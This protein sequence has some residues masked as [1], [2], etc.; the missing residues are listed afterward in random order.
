MEIKEV[1]FIKSVVEFEKD[2]SPLSA[3]HD[4]KMIFFLWRSNVGKSSM[5]NSILGEKNLA[6][7]WD[8]P[9][10]TRLINIFEV[11]KKY[12]CLDF[13]GYWFAVGSKWN[14]VN[15]R[16]MILDYLENNTHKFSKAVMVVDAYVWPTSLD[17]EIYDYLSEKWQEILIILNKIDKTNQKELSESKSKLETLFPDAKYFPYSCKTKINREKLIEEIFS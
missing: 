15:L 9:G 2:Y 10:K 7:S 1:K 11:N 13:P 3:E 8:K 6:F 16:D 17:E 14:K 12:R 4:K 5:I